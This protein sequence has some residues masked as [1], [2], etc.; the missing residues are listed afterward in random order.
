MTRLALAFAAGLVLAPGLALAADSTAFSL[1]I[2]NHRFEP[3]TIEVPAGQKITLTVVNA[4]PT[5]EEFESGPLRRE[6]VVAGGKQIEM[7]VG[8]L[9]PGTYEFV[10][11][12]NQKTARGKLVAK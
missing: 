2:R 9:K 7:T 3:D 4:D 5:P 6:K 8:P 1:T 11:D 12:F 10:G